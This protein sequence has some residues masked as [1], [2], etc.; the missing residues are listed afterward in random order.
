MHKR[1]IYLHKSRAF[2]ERE[3]VAAVNRGERCF[4]VSNSKKYIKA[5]HRMILIE[6]GDHVVM[7]IVTS[8]NSRDEAILR[9]LAN[10]KEEF[11][12]IQVLAGTPSIG[13]GIDMTF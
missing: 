4:I 8:D 7:R 9:F 13:T 10:V 2:L 1:T 5:V 11:C 3:V 6:C 12:R